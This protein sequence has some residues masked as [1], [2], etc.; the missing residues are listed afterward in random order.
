MKAGMLMLA[1]LALTPIAVPAHDDAHQGMMHGVMPGMMHGK[2][3]S[4]H[5]A[6]GGHAQGEGKPGDPKKVSRTIQ[7]LMS[8]DMKFTPATAS[9]KRGE[10]VKFVVRNAGRIKHEMIIGSMEALKQHAELMRK[11]PGMEHDEPNQ[12]TLAPGKSGELV[13]QFTKAGTVDFACLQPGHFEAGM[14][15]TVLVK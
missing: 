10:T 13:W 11:M 5:S 4:G 8:D 7:V 15:G 6:D 3:E 14:M 9:V 1:A 12:V 2:A